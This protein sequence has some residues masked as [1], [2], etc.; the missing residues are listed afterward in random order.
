M[1]AKE[2]GQLALPLWSYLQITGRLELI[3]VVDQ[4]VRMIEYMQH[5][6]DAI[7][8]LKPQALHS[9][10]EQPPTVLLYKY[11]G[12]VPS[13]SAPEDSQPA[14]PALLGHVLQCISG[15]Q[16]T[17]NVAF[18]GQTF[19]RYSPS[20]GGFTMPSDG[21]WMSDID[22][23]VSELKEK[24]MEMEAMV[25]NRS[26]F[27]EAIKAETN[28]FLVKGTGGVSLGSFRYVPSYLVGHEDDATTQELSRLNSEFCER[29][30]GVRQ[31]LNSG[32]AN[33]TFAFSMGLATDGLVCVNALVSSGILTSALAVEFAK[34]WSRLAT[35][36]KDDEAL[37]A[38]IGA[39]VKAGID[40]AQ[41]E[42]DR[43]NDARLMN[44]GVLRHVPVV[45][46]VLSWFSPQ[47]PQQELKG[48]RFTLASGRVEERSE[49][50]PEYDS[51]AKAGSR[52]RSGTVA[53]RES[54]SIGL[55]L[56]LGENNKTVIVA[57]AH[58]SAAAEAGH[59]QPGDAISEINGEDTS[60]WSLEEVIIGL[61]NG[62]DELK[63][64]V[65]PHIEAAKSTLAGS[66]E[67]STES[68]AES[69]ADTVVLQRSNHIIIRYNSESLGLELSATDADPTPT[70][71]S[72]VGVSAG[73]PADVAGLQTGDRLAGID[74]E[75]CTEWSLGQV[76]SVLQ[77]CGSELTISVARAPS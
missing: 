43:E 58:D 39:A 5:S 57:I 10:V 59:M 71:I 46:S 8:Y 65:S 55:E 12:S 31:R 70:G 69:G 41:E 63:I 6:L 67:S 15:L 66:T 18:G 7:P 38:R 68:A 16:G 77:D 53:R 2:H 25:S 3:E 20:D 72:I 60:G 28:L 74:G 17:S 23:Y 13:G 56:R 22:V 14:D 50:L 37:V 42:L 27:E 33:L 76:F 52:R 30:N 1:S 26:A 34:A 49:D 19:L 44:E 54:E 64:G 21:F 36:L 32:R 24:L 73:S 75:D 35:Q 4:P 29:L 61:A 11:V 47:V 9:A 51:V 45:G 40:T 48:R 62:G